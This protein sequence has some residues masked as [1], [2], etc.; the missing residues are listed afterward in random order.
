MTAS[1]DAKL[2]LHGAASQGALNDLDLFLAHQRP[3]LLLRHVSTHDMIHSGTTHIVVDFSTRHMVAHVV[4]T[5]ILE[6][7]RAPQ[8]REPGAGKALR[9]RDVGQ[10]VHVRVQRVPHQPVQRHC[11]EPKGQCCRER[12]V[13]CEW[14][15]CVCVCV[16]VC[17]LCVVCAC[18]RVTCRS[19]SS[20]P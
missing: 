6:N 10:T 11:R 9:S 16:C 3:P 15:V 20:K 18:V 17:V 14:G 8:P 13:L 2:N 4:E 1:D 12:P 5:Q 19:P 7:S